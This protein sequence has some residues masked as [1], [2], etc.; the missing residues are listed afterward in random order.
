MVFTISLCYTRFFEPTKHL[1]T[2]IFKSKMVQN[3][4][5]QVP[6]TQTYTSTQTTAKQPKRLN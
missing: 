5:Q 4:N 2:T 6:Q 1:L 3:K